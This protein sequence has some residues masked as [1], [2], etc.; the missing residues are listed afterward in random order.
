MYTD[1]LLSI[2]QPIGYIYETTPP[3]IGCVVLPILCL[4]AASMVCSFFYWDYISSMVN[5]FLSIDTP[6]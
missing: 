1:S 5:D 6:A 3:L 2:H 4:S